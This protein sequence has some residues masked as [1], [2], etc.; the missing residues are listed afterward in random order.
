MAIEK[1]TRTIILGYQVRCA[2]C[3]TTGPLAETSADACDQAHAA[4]WDCGSRATGY[5][6]L[7]LCPRCYDAR[8]A[9]L[10]VQHPQETTADDS[11][12]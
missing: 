1:L 6:S 12:L 3:G 7:D 9:V 2:D 5:S 8:E 10:N 4:G 11:P